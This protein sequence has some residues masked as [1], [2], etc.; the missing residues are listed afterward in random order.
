MNTRD[1]IPDIDRQGLRNFGLTTGTI[2]AALFGL[3]FP[4]MLE[5]AFPVWPWAILAVLGAWA[6]IAPDSLNPVYRA[7]MRLGL[8]LSK[9]TT[10]LIMGIVF[11]LVI[12]PFGIALRLLGKDPMRRGFDKTATSYRI[13]S[14]KAT[15][16]NLENPF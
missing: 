7:W 10:P 5:S 13:E 3:F 16:E 4:W 8:L 14:I 2:V 12:M 11:F 1:T 15:K 6:L 9:I